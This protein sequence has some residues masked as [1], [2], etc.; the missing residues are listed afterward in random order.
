MIV[1]G[2]AVSYVPIASLFVLLVARCGSSSSQDDGGVDGSSD[3]T[4]L[5]DVPPTVSAPNVDASDSAP[6]DSGI[7][8]LACAAPV[9]V[10]TLA[11]VAGSFS[12]ALEAAVLG[13]KY[14]A[15]WYEVPQVTG[16]NETHIKARAF[17]GNAFGTEIDLGVTNGNMRMSDDGA[18]HAFEMWSGPTSSLRAVFDFSA[19]AFG[20][21]TAFGN[22]AASSS[23]DVGGV[24]A[25][26]FQTNGT[27]AADRWVDGGWSATNL[28]AASP[29]PVDT[30]LLANG[31]NAVLGWYTPNATFHATAF[32]G[33]GWGTTAQTT[34]GD[35]GIVIQQ[36]VVL[37]NGDAVY[38]FEQSGS[39]ESARFDAPTATIGASV[40]VE[41][42]GT[43]SNTNAEEA[44]HVM[45]VDS[46]DRVTIGWIRAVASVT[47]AFV[48]RSFDK[49][50]TWSTPTD[51]GAANSL[52][53]GAD[54]SSSTVVVATRDV[55]TSS[56]IVLHAIQGT[57]TTWSTPI[58]T[59]LE[60]DSTGGYQALDQVARVLVTPSSVVVVAHQRDADAGVAYTV[61]AVTCTL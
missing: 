59:P 54:A 60:S 40:V 27:F 30:R 21:S 26:Y 23:E 48:S 47:H 52:V 5:P 12:P 57:S 46:A 18:G 1:R 35:G 17:D 29:N 14:V 19:L 50:A 41:A 43:V 53:M 7:V 49:G 58:T 10:D 55:A 39:I 11:G 16:D 33:G 15:T 8:S 3:S 51:L 32:D 22:I 42:A 36:Y 61:R 38:M 2:F 45:A 6:N 24:F 4:T 28:A 13:H 34:Q 9:R 44:R 25:A 20:A 37:S 56:G 31:S